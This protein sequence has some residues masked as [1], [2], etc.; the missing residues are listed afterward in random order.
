MTIFGKRWVNR[1]LQ[2]QVR[3]QRMN[4]DEKRSLLTCN[5]YSHAQRVRKKGLDF[6][7]HEFT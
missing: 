2:W 5:V 1:L 4:D 6:M 7:I 3:D